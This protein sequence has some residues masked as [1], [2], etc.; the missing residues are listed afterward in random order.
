LLVVSLGVG[1]L[2][3]AACTDNETTATRSDPSSPTLTSP[4]ASVPAPAPGDTALAPGAEVLRFETAADIPCVPPT[5][6]V[7]VTYE[8]RGLDAV[9]FVVDGATAPTADAPPAGATVAVSVPCDG[10]VHTV[11][12]VGSGAD[13][14]AFAS[15]AVATRPA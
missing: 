6:S 4:H 12:L 9:G 14:P 5:A 11:M 13:G 10:K 1:G 3:L 8:T 15:K 7:E 2:F